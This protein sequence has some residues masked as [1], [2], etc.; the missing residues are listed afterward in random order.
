MIKEAT[1]TDLWTMSQRDSEPLRTFIERFK[2]V[3]SNIAI[4]DDAAIGALR[5]ALMF[6]SRLREDLI[7]ARP[8]TLDDALHRANRYIEVEEKKAEMDRQLKEC[9][10][11]KRNYY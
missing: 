3:V 1:N 6:G 10:A 5:N 9:N 8:S 7:I 4:K 11:K 2:K